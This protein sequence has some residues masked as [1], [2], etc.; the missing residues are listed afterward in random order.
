MMYGYGAAPAKPISVIIAFN[1]NASIS[2]LM[3][4]SWGALAGAFLGPF[5]FGLF[6]KKIT[7]ASVWTSFVLG[8]G[9][10]VGHMILFG[11]GWFP[12]LAKTAASF[13]LNLAS[14]INAG[15][16]TMILSIVVVP[17]VSLFTV[18]PDEKHLDSVFSCYDLK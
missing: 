14:P 18:K 2:T 13:P 7:K 15:A 4:Y 5:M 10:T 1:K 16:I 12:E 11:F 3:S 6:S 8:I 17:L 9:L